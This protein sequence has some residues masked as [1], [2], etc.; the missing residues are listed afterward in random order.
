MTQ[1]AFE[2]PGL[3]CR[4]GQ[5]ARPERV[6]FCELSQA[7]G[8]AEASEA[9][10]LE[11]VVACVSNDMTASGAMHTA[12]EAR[13][14][15]P[16]DLSVIAFDDIHFAHNLIEGKSSRRS[17][18]PAVATELVVRRSTSIPRESLSELKERSSA[19]ASKRAK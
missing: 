2:L 10:A 8:D 16:E 17:V 12:F 15:V 18:Q 11:Q 19:T 14:K 13:L 1:L 6:V 5:R 4:N 7:F 9:I 3:G